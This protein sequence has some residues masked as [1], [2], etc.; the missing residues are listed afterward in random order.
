MTIDRLE[1]D[2]VI[3]GSGAGGAAIAGE[4]AR[5]GRN[6]IVI[7]AGQQKTNPVGSHVRN[8]SPLESQ[9]PNI[10]SLLKGSLVF[11]GMAKE[12]PGD[13]KDWKVIYEVGGLF[14]YWTC[15]CPPI[16]DAELSPCLS[17]TDWRRLLSR[18]YKLLGVS[19]AFGKGSVRQ[20]RIINCLEKNF[21]N[22]PRDHAI[23]PMPVAA[24]KSNSEVHFASTSDLI[25]SEYPS[26]IIKLLPNHVASKIKVKADH[27]VGVLVQPI[28]AG[29]PIEILANVVVVAAGTAGTPQLLASSKLDVGPALGAYMFDHPAIGSRVVLK[30]NI[31][32]G[33]KLDDPQFTVLIPFDVNRPWQQQVCRFPS[34]PGSVE[35]IAEQHKTG[36]IFTFSSMDVVAENRLEFLLDQEDKL[37]L[38]RIIGHYHLSSGDYI[39]LG[40]GLNEHF[41]MASAIGD[42]TNYSWTPN[43]FG[44]GWSTHFM[45]GC[46]MGTADDGTSVVNSSGRL[47]RYDNI[48]VAGNSVHDVSNAGN[49]TA[50]TIAFALNT[51]DTILLAHPV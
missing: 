26:D 50:T 32:D 15:N 31:L 1:T 5:N 14:S 36:D 46:R 10:G 21:T 23:Q 33:V 16:H 9:L 27:A 29:N 11:P 43:F 38:P 41:Q 49:P 35:L 18:V 2:V 17:I 22:L 4:L 51:V 30:P 24:T 39:R 7:E 48:Y 6:S 25:G 34:D 47:W 42:L 19:T 40:N 28:G 37:G 44:P 13:I 45:G 3:L 8:S 12:P 20:D